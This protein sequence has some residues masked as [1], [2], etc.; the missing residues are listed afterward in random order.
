M[1]RALKG[2]SES[3]GSRKVSFHSKRNKLW[4]WRSKFGCIVKV[5][6]HPSVQN[7]HMTLDERW[8][9]IVCLMRSWLSYWFSKK[10]SIHSRY[11]TL[12]QP[13]YNVIW[14]FRALRWTLKQRYV[15]AGVYNLTE[16]AHFF[17]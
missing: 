3:Y 6:V 13:S 12:F 15:Q 10:R 7:V 4:Q 16:G 14:T 17:S 9:D 5:I 1:D 2:S 8:K 11:T